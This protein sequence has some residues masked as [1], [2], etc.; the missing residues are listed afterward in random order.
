[1]GAPSTPNSMGSES[2]APAPFT[3]YVPQPSAPPIT[4]VVPSAANPGQY[5]AQKPPPSFT[6]PP[7]TYTDPRV[8]DTVELCNFAI[9][10]LK[11]IHHHLCQ[12]STS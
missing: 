11:V 1:M 10:A 8:Q 9:L 4:P 5:Y 7:T 6:R 3:A 2:P 12:I